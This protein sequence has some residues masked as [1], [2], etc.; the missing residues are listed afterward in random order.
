MNGFASVCLGWRIRKKYFLVKNKEQPKER[1]LLSWVGTAPTPERLCRSSASETRPLAASCYWV[2]WSDPL[3]VKVQA[4]E[5][6][7]RVDLV[8][9]VQVAKGILRCSEGH[10]EVPDL[11]LLQ[12]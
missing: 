7:A 11:L 1:Y 2:T 8:A 10:E 3:A 12:G 4:K 9:N 5:T 6:A